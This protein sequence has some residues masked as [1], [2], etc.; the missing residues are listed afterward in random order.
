MMNEFHEKIKTHPEA[1]QQY[2]ST[3]TDAQRVQLEAAKKARMESL[4]KIRSRFELR[5]TGKPTRPTGVFGIFVKDV[6]SKMT[7]HSTKSFGTVNNTQ[8]SFFSTF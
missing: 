3:L 8:I 4:K 2:Y 1:L 7:D 5:K 6:Y